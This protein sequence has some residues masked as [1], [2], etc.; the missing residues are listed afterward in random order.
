MDRISGSVSSIRQNPAIFQL[1]GIRSDTE[2]LKTGYLVS[3][4]PAG[5]PVSS[6]ENGRISGR[7]DIRQHCYPIHPYIS[8][9]FKM[10]RTI[11]YDTPTIGMNTRHLTLY[12]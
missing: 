11:N 9:M 10:N 6:F 8:I 7:P 3:K 5:N 12:E 1:S 4:F 2:Y